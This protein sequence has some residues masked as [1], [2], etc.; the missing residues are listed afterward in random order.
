MGLLND[1]QDLFLLASEIEIVLTICHQ[2]AQLLRDEKLLA[3]SVH[4]QEQNK[5]QTA[6]LKT[7][8]KQRAA[9]TVAIPA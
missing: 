7:Q 9:Q 1:L 3:L 8:I 2:I 6:W 4:Q 5:R